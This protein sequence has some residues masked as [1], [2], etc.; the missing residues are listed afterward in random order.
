MK[1]RIYVVALGIGLLIGL[2]LDRMKGRNA[3]TRTGVDNSVAIEDSR[4]RRKPEAAGVRIARLITAES[5]AMDESLP[6]DQAT[7]ILLSE[8]KS[9]LRT[10][11]FLK[12][13]IQMMTADQIVQALMNGEIQ[14]EAE[15]REVA[16]RLATEDPEGTF[17]RAQA[18]DFRIYGV[19]NAYAFFDTLMEKWADVDAPAA[20]VSL[21]RMKRGG[22]QQETTLRFSAYWAKIDPAAA[23]RHFSDLVYLR[24]MQGKEQKFFTDNVFATQIVKSWQQKDEE[25][26]REFIGNLPAGRERDAFVDAAGKLGKADH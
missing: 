6:M 20:L 24:N 19:A 25:G 17:A 18:G 10:R 11:A 22:A 2:T 3:S 15:L 12:N 26:M 14:T 4:I 16:S 8:R 23:A 5:P 21:K 9:P 13:R 7:E 1:Y